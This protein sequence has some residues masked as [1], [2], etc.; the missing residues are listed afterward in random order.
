MNSEGFNF[1]IGKKVKIVF[2]ENGMCVNK[3]VFNRSLK[4]F[5]F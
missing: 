5:S 2:L 3:N 1:E 4:K